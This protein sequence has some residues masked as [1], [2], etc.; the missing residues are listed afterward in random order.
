MLVKIG[1]DISLLNFYHNTSKY[2]RKQPPASQG[3]KAELD[4]KSGHCREVGCNIMTYTVTHIN[5]G[6]RRQLLR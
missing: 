6:V 5:W 2:H 3:N 1:V 4:L